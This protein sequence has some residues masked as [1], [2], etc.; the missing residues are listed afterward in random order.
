[1]VLL[2]FCSR[3]SGECCDSDVVIP[4]TAI[5]TQVSGLRKIYGRFQLRLDLSTLNA[6]RVR[7]VMNDKFHILKD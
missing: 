4:S 6:L 5:H 1:M 2:V 3:S 7:M